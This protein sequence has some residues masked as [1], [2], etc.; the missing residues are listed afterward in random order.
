M[1]KSGRELLFALDIGT[2]TVTCLVAEVGQPTAENTF[3]SLNLLGVGR[4]VSTGMRRGQVENIEATIKSIQDAI[5]QAETAADCKIPCV[6]TGLSGGHI[7]SENSQGNVKISGSEVA[8]ADLDRVIDAARAVS[9]PPD[10]QLLHL[11][12]QEFIVDQQSG[13]REPIGISGV[14][15]EARVHLITGAVSAAQNLVKCIKRCGLAVEDMV[16][17]PLADSYAVLSPEEK[18]VGV[19]L[20]NI[21]AGTTDIAIFCDDVVQYT[22]VITIGGAHVTS[23][24]VAALRVS[25]QS[26][27]EIKINHGCAFA[28]KASSPSKRISLEAGVAGGRTREFSQAELT[29]VIQARYEELL[30]LV[31]EEIRRSGLSEMIKAGGIVFTGGAV[32]IANFLPLAEKIFRVDVRLG[33]PSGITG[34]ASILSD[35]AY[36]TSVGLLH[37]IK[38][39]QDQGFVKPKRL[40]SSTGIGF[41]NRIKNMTKALLAA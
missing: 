11:L 26:A 12:T 3:A 22:K 28:S 33:T 27:E 9:I 16:F 17:N 20:V 41:I 18:K 19:C 1:N 30:G 34:P 25:S 40:R 24:I 39:Q 7:R 38:L 8:Q 36:A 35:P 6:V 29:A 13:I 5:D 23:D 2:S 31:N 10:Q 21:G 32:K 14:R 15:L 4:Q 37:Y